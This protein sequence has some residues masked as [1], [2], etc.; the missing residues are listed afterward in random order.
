MEI[1]EFVVKQSTKCVAISEFVSVSVKAK[2]GSSDFTLATATMPFRSSRRTLLGF[3]TPG[4]PSPKSPK[5]QDY[6]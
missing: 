2:T 3:R 1:C 4:R 6:P 5:K